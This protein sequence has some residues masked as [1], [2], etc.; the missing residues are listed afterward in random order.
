LLLASQTSTA[1]LLV[2]S[3]ELA[4]RAAIKSK[5]APEVLSNCKYW[6][7]QRTAKSAPCVSTP[8]VAGLWQTSVSQEQVGG[9]K[10]KAR[11]TSRPG[12]IADLQLASLLK[13]RIETEVKTI[14]TLARAFGQDGRA[15]TD[16]D[17]AVSRLRP[18][19]GLAK[20]EADDLL[21]PGAT[22]LSRAQN[23]FV[24]NLAARA[25][26]ETAI[27]RKDRSPML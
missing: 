5:G 26:Q 27:W 21:Y 7:V 23:R 16:D 2:E 15:V 19:E 6:G 14:I 4:R 11:Q 12:G 24:S 13:Q 20:R 18:S 25:S 3:S 9:L 8:A 22:A 17:S 1:K 10:L